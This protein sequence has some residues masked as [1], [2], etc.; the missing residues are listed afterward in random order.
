MMV[1]EV[2][3]MPQPGWD[4]LSAFLQSHLFPRT[5]VVENNVK[6]KNLVV[7][8]NSNIVNNLAYSHMNLT[9]VSNV[10]C[11]L[12]YLHRLKNEYEPELK[13]YW[14]QNAITMTIKKNRESTVKMRTKQKY[15][16][17]DADAHCVSQVTILLVW[18]PLTSWHPD[19]QFCVTADC[20][21]RN[22]ENFPN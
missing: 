7:S 21:D 1:E 4:R 3:I 8:V 9:H 18:Q 5:R 14:R 20:D 12:S 10:W 11:I 22:R 19:S 2:G 15:G 13:T 17:S 16:I 6:I